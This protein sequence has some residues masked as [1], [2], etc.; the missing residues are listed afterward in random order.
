MNSLDIFSARALMLAL[1]QIHSTKDLS[2]LPQVLFS[3]LDVEIKVR[4][5]IKVSLQHF[6]IT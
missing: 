2:D 6:E 3:T 1:E 5:F 4:N